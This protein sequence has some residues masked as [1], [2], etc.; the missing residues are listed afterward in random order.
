MRYLTDHYGCHAS[1]VPHG[2]NHTILGVL[3]EPKGAV[4]PFGVQCP[5]RCA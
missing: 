1:R 2:Q 5:S 3:H 4:E